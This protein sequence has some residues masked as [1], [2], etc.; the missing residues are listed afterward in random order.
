MQKELLAGQVEPYRRHKKG[1]MA[2]WVF[3]EIEIP[4]EELRK[5]GEVAEERRQKC[6]SRFRAF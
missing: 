5:T 1:W 4:V 3:W 6:A 2:C